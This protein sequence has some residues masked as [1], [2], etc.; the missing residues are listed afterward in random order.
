MTMSTLAELIKQ[1]MEERGLGME[2]VYD[3]LNEVAQSNGH[4]IFVGGLEWNDGT[5]Y[6]ETIASESA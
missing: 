5:E 3:A 2:D 4:K 1:V 6:R